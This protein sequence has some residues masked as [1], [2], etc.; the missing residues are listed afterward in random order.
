[1]IWASYSV[2][3][4]LPYKALTH[5]KSGKYLDGIQRT[6]INLIGFEIKIVYNHSSMRRWQLLVLQSA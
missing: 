3:R 1:M 6:S 4:A 2:R 5:V